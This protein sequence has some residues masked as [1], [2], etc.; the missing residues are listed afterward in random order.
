MTFGLIAGNGNFPFLVLSGAKKAGQKLV[1]AAIREET[2][3]R[4][5]EAADKV[6]FG[7][8]TFFENKCRYLPRV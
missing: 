3:Q 7:P 8:P 1:V 5:E 4:I 2:D 6:I